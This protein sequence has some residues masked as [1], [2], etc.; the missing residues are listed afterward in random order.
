[1]IEFEQACEL[2]FDNIHPLGAEKRLIED[3]IGWVL[4]EDIV[5][6][7]NVVPFRN[8]AMDGFAVNSLWLKECSDANPRVM[9]IDSTLFAG[10]SEKNHSPDERVVKVMTG[11]RVP[12][13]FDAVVPFEEAEY[14]ENEVRFSAPVA[15]GQ[16]IRLPGEDITRGQKLFTKGTLLGRLDIGIL[17]A[18][19][20]RSV[21]TYRKPSLAIIATG[22]E[23]TNPGED[24]K[25]DRIYE[26]NSFTILSL[27]APYCDKIE[28]IHSIPDIKE[29]LHKVLNLPHD[30]IV[31]SGG[32]S[33]GERDLVVNIAESCG[34]QRIFHKARIKPGKPVYFAVR[35]KQVLFGLPG[36]T[37]STAVTCSVFLIPALKKMAGFTN[38]KLSL[39]PAKLALGEFRK[40]N[41]KLIW[42]GFI[43][44]DADS[45]IARYS[46][47]K[48]SGAL[49]AL[50]GTDGLVF[51]D[52]VTAESP[53]AAVKV[54]A[55][56][57]I[58]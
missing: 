56:R 23:L 33:A 24:L 2:V 53:E 38:Y 54:I 49:T 14:S 7:I 31:T 36:N 17:A 52:P 12:D 40:S 45:V 41:R 51:Q 43:T 22:D 15:T 4:A 10:N 57:H 50:L 34:W 6:P 46:P 30:V 26:A 27:V 18:I 29:E 3:A 9:R 21:L 55:W 32:V 37:L 39:K 48:S 8:S 28:R 44:E 20:L 11:A 5:S 19:G 16:H 58:F 35:G 25:D 13:G 1:M 47:K 42:P